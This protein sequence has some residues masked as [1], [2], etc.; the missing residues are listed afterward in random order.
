MGN[1]LFQEARKAVMQAKQ[2]ANDQADIELDRAI[3]IAKN[4]LSSAYAHSNTAE[5]TQLR[6][7]Q[8]ELDQ[9]TR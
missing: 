1:R 5:K 2:S 9:L 8:E 4:A 6:Q 3:A 7:F